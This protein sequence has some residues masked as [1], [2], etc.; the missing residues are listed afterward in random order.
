MAIHRHLQSEGVRPLENKFLRWVLVA[1][2]SA[3]LCSGSRERFISEW[4]P[5]DR[6]IVS[7]RADAKAR[8]LQAGSIKKFGVATGCLLRHI[9]VAIRYW[10]RGTVLIAKASGHLQPCGLRGKPL[11]ANCYAVG[12]PGLCCQNRELYS[13]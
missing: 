10:C 8:M 4:G 7:Q 12:E 3:A 13:L 5:S 2:K 11:V 1:S 9:L 6:N